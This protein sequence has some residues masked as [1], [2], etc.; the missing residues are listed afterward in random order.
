MRDF[1]SPQTIDTWMLFAIILL[2]VV[3]P[4]GTADDVVHWREGSI[5]IPTDPT[6]RFRLDIY[7]PTTAGS[8]PVMVFLTGL[9][10]TI[11]ATDYTTFLKN[12]ARQKVIVIG[13][14][15]IENIAPEKMAVHLVD[16]LQWLI[17]PNDGATRLFAEHKAVTGVK[18]DVG[19]L[20][21]LSHSSAGHP[22]AQYL[23]G[24]CGP[25]K[26]T[27]MM[28]PVD[29]LDPFGIFDDF[30][31]RM[32]MPAACSCSTIS[33]SVDP[34]NPLPYRIPTLIISA[35]LGKVLLFLSSYSQH[36]PCHCRQRSFA[37]R[38]SS[39]RLE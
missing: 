31:T 22:L 17:K 14:A 6:I 12:I 25:L 4:V 20:G 19:R 30:V 29:G 26:L 35:G 11:P 1:L 9:S 7:S 15:K 27:V 39:M 28:N 34:P 36:D 5:I 33:S 18:P 23:N 13:I 16:F 8:Y 10:G 3:I 38:V 24:T 2:F 21:F 37:P 32:K